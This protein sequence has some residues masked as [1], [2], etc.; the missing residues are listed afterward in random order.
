MKPP[1]KL[2]IVGGGTAGW[3]AANLFVHKWS[4]KQVQITLIESPEIG[5]VGVGEGS[6]P[7][8]KRFFKMLN[9]A[10]SDW[11]HRCNATYKANIRFADWSPKSGIESY[12]HPFTSQTDTFTS[13]AFLV[14]CQTRRLGLDSHVVPE[15]FLINGVLARQGKAPVTPE[16][17]PFIM[18]YGYHFDSGLL[19]QFLCELGVSKGVN[20]IQANVSGVERAQ[21][22][23]IG[24][25]IY[26]EGEH[27]EADFFVDCTG[28][29]SLLMQQTL[30]VQFNSYKE[31]LFNDRAVVMPTPISGSIPVETVST[32]LSAGWCWK[33][34]LT[35][36]FGNGYVYSSDF[37]CE[38]D[39][40]TEFR[41]HLNMLDAEQACF[42]LKMKVGQLERHWSHNCVALGLSQGFIEPL[43]ATALHLVQIAAEQFIIDFE[44]GEFSS[45]YRQSY[46][47]KIK[48]RFDRVRDYIVA[49]YK[50]NT[51]DDSDYWRANRENT[52]LSDSLTQVLDVW[53]KCGDLTA[54]IERQGISNHF[55]TVSWHCLLA[56][57]GAFPEL[58]KNQPGKGDLY[59]EQDIQ[60]FQQGCALNF[61]GHNSQLNQLTMP[62]Y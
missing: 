20:H 10:E 13:R 28:F 15:D 42:H 27:I 54:E 50:L 19:G 48:N 46:N 23:D 25:V 11:M 17:F 56:G 21:N 53:Y 60:R 58:A 3:I 40:E 35:G 44:Q 7:T 8:L 45:A 43:E 22:G 2:A 33:I 32:A 55:D 47:S 24:A 30:G 14:N 49:H 52:H 37:I 1:V 51:R 9:V 61:Q 57:Y 34:P 18:E 41:K 38:D 26:D 39:A 36:R 5:T 62:V 31:N 6:T 59:Q 29:S 12:S 16:N 4:Q